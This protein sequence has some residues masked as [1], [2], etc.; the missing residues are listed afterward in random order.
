MPARAVIGNLS[1]GGPDQPAG[2]IESVKPKLKFPLFRLGWRAAARGFMEI[3]PGQAPSCSSAGFFKDSRRLK[4]RIGRFAPQ[5]ARPPPG[6]SSAT[7]DPAAARSSGGRP[8]PAFDPRSGSGPWCPPP[9]PATGSPSAPSP[10]TRAPSRTR[11]PGGTPEPAR[12]V[13]R[14]PGPVAPPRRA[15]HACPGPGRPAPGTGLPVPADPPFVLQAEDHVQLFPV[16]RHRPVRVARLARRLREAPAMFGPVLRPIGVRRLDVADPAQPHLLDQTVLVGPVGAFDP[17]LRL[18]RGGMQ[19]LHPQPPQHPPELRLAVLLADLVD[20]EHAVPLAGALPGEGAAGASSA[21]PASAAL[22]AEA[23][24]AGAD[25]AADPVAPGPSGLGQAEADGAIA[26]RG[27][28]GL[29]EHGRADGQRAVATGPDRAQPLK[30]QAP[31]GLPPASA[32]AARL[33]RAG[34]RDRQGG[35]GRHD[36]GDALLRLPLQAVHRGRRGQPLPGRGALY[37]RATAACAARCTEMAAD[38]EGVRRQWAEWED[39]YNR[40]RPHQSLGL[41][42]PIQ[43][44]RSRSSSRACSQMS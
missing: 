34:R 38:L 32:G 18:R 22:P 30:N 28:R 16:V 1:P 4:K 21:Q 9:E 31:A 10:A 2:Q 41:K 35:A 19:V 42:T 24:G 6:P 25:A 3:P 7:D 11:P 37:S 13:P 5:P 44:I 26:P 20:P 17:S 36:D 43:Y 8:G 29:G 33:G 23:L 27:L 39:T 15:A 40:V 12:P 14:R